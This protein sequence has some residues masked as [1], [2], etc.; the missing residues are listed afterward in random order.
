YWGNVNSVGPRSCYDE[1]KRY[2]E[3]AVMAAHRALGQDTRIVRIFNTYG[4]RMRPE[5]GRAVTNF[6][7]QAKAGRDVTVYGDGSQTRSFCYI[8][9]LVEGIVRLLFSTETRPVNLGNPNEVSILQV[10][11]LAIAHLG[12][13]SQITHLPLPED[14]PQKRKPDISRAKEVL[15]WEPQVGMEQGFQLTMDYFLATMG[16]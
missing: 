9:D 1:A 11:Q 3:A 12:S 8:S 6:L 16:E 13:T 7:M 2:A 10:A 14:D 15:G 4:P 5:D